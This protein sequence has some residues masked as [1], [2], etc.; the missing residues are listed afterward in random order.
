LGLG[1]VSKGGRRR[2]LGRT[3]LST[4]VILAWL[5]F[6]FAW[7]EKPCKVSCCLYFVM[8]LGR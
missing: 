1:G 5:L 3:V 4:I 6:W 8:K 7:N 2:G